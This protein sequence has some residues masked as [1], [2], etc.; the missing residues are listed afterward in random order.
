MNIFEIPQLG[1]YKNI[2]V[3]FLTYKEFIDIVEK[4]GFKTIYKKMNIW[5]QKN[6]VEFVTQ[7]IF[8]KKFLS[9]NI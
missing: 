9:S 1:I 4:V 6:I 5:K 3:S 8:G 2:I 7:K